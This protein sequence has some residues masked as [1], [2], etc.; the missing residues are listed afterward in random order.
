[1][2]IDFHI[3]N[4]QLSFLFHKLLRVLVNISGGHKLPATNGDTFMS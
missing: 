2:H 3:F 1:M 4:H